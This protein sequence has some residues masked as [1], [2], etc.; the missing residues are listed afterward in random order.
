MRTIEKSFVSTGCLIGTPKLYSRLI[1]LLQYIKVFAMALAL[2]TLVACPG[3][4]PINNTT[5]DTTAEA[6]TEATLTLALTDNAAQVV[7]TISSGSPAIAKVTVTDTTGA[8]ANAVVTFTIDKNELAVL[9]PSSGI[10]ITNSSGVATISLESASRTAAGAATLTATSQVGEEAVSQSIGFVVGA[11][12]VTISAPTFGVGTGALSAYGSTSVSVSVFTDGVLETIPQVVSF[13]SACSVNGKAE[14]TAEVATI[15]GVATASYLDNGCAGNDTVTASVSGITTATGT[16]NVT[17]PEAGSIQFEAV[18]PSS[19]FI[20]P[21]GMGGQESALVTFKVADSSGN[22]IGGK[23]VNFSLNTSVGG[24][25]IT[26]ASA[27]SDPVTGNVVV[28]VQAGTIATPVRVSASTIEGSTTLISQSSQLVISTG[29]PDQQNFSLSASEFNIE[30]WKYDGETTTITARLADHFNNPVLDG[31]AVSFIAEGGSVEPA[32]FTQNGVCS[33]VFTS[34]NLKP[35]NGRVTILAY[36]IG[37]EGFTD[38]VANGLA[39]GLSEMIDANGNSTDMP[40]AFLDINENGTRDA[41]EAYTDFNV[42]GSYSAANGEYNGVL[43]DPSVTPGSTPTACNTQ[44]SIHVRDSITIIFSSSFANIDI[45]DSANNSLSSINLPQ[46]NPAVGAGSARSFKV[47]VLDENRNAMPIGSTISFSTDNGTIL[48]PSS[49][50]VKNT[51][52]CNT[53]GACPAS[54]ASPSFGDYDVVMK[55]DA[56]FSLT[57]DATTGLTTASCTDDSNIGA[58]TVTVT[59]PLSNET[60]AFVTVTD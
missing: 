51:A 40:E 37:E 48:S 33:V 3:D 19:G 11:T 1:H 10:A 53:G 42:D 22:P 36:A 16:L 57:T 4:S 15:G 5:N 60:T 2:S 55:S 34:Q 23:E 12:S 46:C 32:C 59:S 28:S 45:L 21:R 54:A 39:D 38:F 6:T 56:V 7:T 41:T 13:T 35:D 47:R 31:T 44:K 24:I 20:N 49:H 8:V 14:L 29:I 58:F 43:C 50:V 30:G 9:S 17:P 25:T 52:G 27:I 18:S 26:P